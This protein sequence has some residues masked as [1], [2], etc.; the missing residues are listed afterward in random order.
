MSDVSLQRQAGQP[1]VGVSG[2]TAVTVTTLVFAVIVV[3]LLIVP[4]SLPVGPMYWD[5]FIYYDGIIRVLDGQIPS[6]DFEAPVGALNYWLVT[7][8][9]SLFPKAQP[10]LLVHFSFLIITLPIIAVIAR[11][12]AKRSAW[13]GFGVLLPFLFFAALPFDTIDFYPYPGVDGFGSYNRHGAHLMYLVAATCMFMPRRKMQAALLAILTV[14]LFLSKITAFLAGGLILAWAFFAGLIAPITVLYVSAAFLATLGILEASFGMI[15][16]YLGGII[17]LATANS[18]A[19]L[20]RFLTVI[21]QRLDVIA[22]TAFLSVVV[23]LSQWR[24]AP[25]WRPPHAQNRRILSFSLQRM[26]DHDGLAILV[27]L[28]AGLVYETQNTGSHAFIMVWPAVL[29]MLMRLQGRGVALKGAILLLTAL[30][31]LPT[32]TK[33]GHRAARALLAGVTYQQLPSD[34]LGVMGQVTAKD[35][36]L[37]RAEILRDVYA[38]EPGAARLI[39]DRG[40][41]PSAIISSEPDFQLLWLKMADEAV[42]AIRKLEETSGRRFERIFTLDFTNPFPFLLNRSGPRGV[43]IGADPFR[44]VPAMQDLAFKDIS[45]PGLV[46]LPTCPDMT[47]RRVLLS[48]YARALEGHERIRLTGCYDAFVK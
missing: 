27:M 43:A 14:S 30:A 47:S 18:D 15:S 38:K 33:T 25:S 24:H 48:I 13:A 34:N 12:A 21:S 39:A 41:M 28:A 4:L 36:F 10:L 40:E 22:A 37:T 23:F 32:L 31:V 46:L 9:Y 44:T 1:T 19:L 3:A 35:L 8:L 26:L 17:H 11:E 2:A 16:A 45:G 5:T 6:V 7:A 29:R 20:P 42:E